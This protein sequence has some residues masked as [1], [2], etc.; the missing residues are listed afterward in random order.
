MNVRR[1]QS[2]FLSN[3]LRTKLILLLAVTIVAVHFRVRR[4]KNGAFHPLLA[5]IVIAMIVMFVESKTKGTARLQC[6]LE[7]TAVT[8]D[9]VGFVILVRPEDGFILFNL[10]FLRNEGSAYYPDV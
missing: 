2:K 8:N 10:Q 6:L 7:Q 5:K 3:F 9:R 1:I 4:D